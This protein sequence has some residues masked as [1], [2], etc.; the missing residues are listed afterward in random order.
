MTKEEFEKGYCDRS[1]ITLE[2]YRECCVTLSCNCEDD[3]CEGWAS[4]P[5]KEIYIRNHKRKHM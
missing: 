5:N 3:S 4:I 1:E 2:E